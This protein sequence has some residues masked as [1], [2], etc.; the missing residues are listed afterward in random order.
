M[1][2]IS[3][4]SSSFQIDFDTGSA[5]LF[6]PA[7]TCNEG[8][9]VGHSR[10]SPTSSIVKVSF[11]FEHVAS[12]SSTADFVVPF[13]S[14][15]ARS[16]KQGNFSIQ[17]GDGSSSSG[18]IYQDSVRPASSFSTLFRRVELLSLTVDTSLP[19]ALQMSIAGVSIT[20]QTFSAVT[21]MSDSFV[22]SKV[23]ADGLAGMRFQ[24]LAHTYSPPFFQTMISQGVVS[25]PVF[26]FR[27]AQKNSEL[28]ESWLP[29]ILPFFVP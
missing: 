24:A 22:K 26:S 10:F 13:T 20:S 28:C 4:G 19:L 8:G 3:I 6:V 18:P 17:Y 9:C 7:D 11:C 16:Q 5:D 23:A 25:S 15:L 12:V 27:I 2:P 1:G 29:S 21:K 14:S